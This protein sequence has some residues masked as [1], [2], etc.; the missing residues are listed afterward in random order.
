MHMRETIVVIGTR[1]YAIRAIALSIRF[2]QISNSIDMSI[3]LLIDTITLA[4]TL[5]QS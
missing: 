4:V 3:Y 5:M 1:H 2:N